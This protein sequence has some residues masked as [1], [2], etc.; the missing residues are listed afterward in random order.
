MLKEKHFHQKC[1]STT[2]SNNISETDRQLI[3]NKNFNEPITTWISSLLSHPFVRWPF[4]TYQE[5]I[6]YPFLNWSLTILK[7][8][9]LTHRIVQCQWKTSCFDVQHEYNRKGWLKITIIFIVASQDGRRTERL[10]FIREGDFYIFNSASGHF[11]FFFCYTVFC[12]CPKLYS[13]ENNSVF[14]KR[15]VHNWTR[16]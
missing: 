13:W 2:F 6:S 10:N 9:I 11:F 7:L 8:D 16:V 4:S 14:D 15:S 12:C 3:R 1:K 5:T